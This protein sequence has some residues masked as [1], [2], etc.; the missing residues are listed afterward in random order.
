MRALIVAL[1]L[2]QL[3]TINAAYSACKLPENLSHSE[4]EPGV[5]FSIIYTTGS[6]DLDAE[7]APKTSALI[8]FQSEI[9]AV[10]ETD[11]LFLLRKQADIFR[12]IIPYEMNRFTNII[13]GKLGQITKIGCLVGTLFSYNITAFGS[14]IE[15]SS[16]VLTKKTNL[17]TIMKIYTHWTPNLSYPGVENSDI[18]D[19]M[20]EKDLK[21][22]WTLEVQLHNHPFQLNNQFGDIAGTV[23]PSGSDLKLYRELYKKWGLKEA[24]ITNGFHTGKYKE[25]D[26]NSEILN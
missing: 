2:F 22:G 20:I 26:F 5:F 12:N 10:T 24:W 3:F 19:R 23:I 15:F 11:Q 8:K 9:Q 14:D 17:K 18:I 7:A 4:L 25:K 16:F 13:T 6:T 21:S 1:F